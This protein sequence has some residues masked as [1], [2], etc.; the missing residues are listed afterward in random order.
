MS[1]SHKEILSEGLKKDSEPL[2]ISF[3]LITKSSQD[4]IKDILQ[5]IAVSINVQL[6]SEDGQY[7]PFVP[8]YEFDNTK[9]EDKVFLFGTT[10]CGKS[11]TVYEIIKERMSSFENIY[12]FNPKYKIGKESER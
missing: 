5:K 1:I 9:H 3:G 12:I 10:G 2:D 7:F 11:R 6:L 8:F 4:E